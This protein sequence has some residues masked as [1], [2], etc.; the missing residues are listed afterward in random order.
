MDTVYHESEK[1]SNWWTSFR[2]KLGMAAIKIWLTV[3]MLIVFGAGISISW[4][5]TMHL[6]ATFGMTGNEALLFTVFVEA[7]LIICETVV[8]ILALKGIKNPW[9]VKLGLAFGVGIN[10][11]GNVA[12]YVAYG[13]PGII[14]GLC[15]P[16]GTM[17]A[18]GALGAGLVKIQAPSESEKQQAEI[19]NQKSRSE[20]IVSSLQTI[21]GLFQKSEKQDQKND[22]FRNQKSEIRNQKA[23]IRQDESEKPIQKSDQKNA[24]DL[25]KGQNSESEKTNQKSEKLEGMGVVGEVITGNYSSEI[26]NQK[27]EEPVQKPE[28]DK[29][30]KQ[31]R[32]MT[33]RKNQK[34]DQKSE[35]EKSVQKSEIRN[36]KKSESEKVTH[37]NQKSDDDTKALKT[38]MQ[39]YEKTGKKPKIKDIMKK[40]VSKYRAE[41]ARKQ[42]IDQF[43]IS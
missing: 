43:K 36:R 4:M 11:W 23:E 20:K 1:K 18:I 2:K 30:E 6:A 13:I 10:G 29:S 39:L 12:A 19:R 15:I 42:V 28:N 35:S 17:I 14:L 21:K 27:L 24:S 33:I 34:S 37:L 16:I 8:I 31:I 7:C 9:Q 40:G 26:R 32:K 5:H 38:A 3:G 41:K 22:D 25:G